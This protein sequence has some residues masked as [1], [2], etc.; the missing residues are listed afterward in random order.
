MSDRWG[1]S[2]KRQRGSRE[3]A[4]NGPRRKTDN[5]KNAP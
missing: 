1:S 4:L 5:V 2:E 3:A